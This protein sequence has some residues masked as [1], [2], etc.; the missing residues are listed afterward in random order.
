M[1]FGSRFALTRKGAQ[2]HQLRHGSDHQRY[3]G[4]CIAD[5]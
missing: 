5:T 4:Y 1:I 2:G 3:N